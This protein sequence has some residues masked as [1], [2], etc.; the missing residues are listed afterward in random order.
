MSRLPR[1]AVVAAC[2]IL[3]CYSSV[4][5]AGMLIHLPMTEGT[6]TTTA[7]TGTIGG[8]ATIETGLTWLVNGGPAGINNAISFGTVDDDTTH[9]DGIMLGPTLINDQLDSLPDYTVTM[10]IRLNADMSGNTAMHSLFDTRDIDG[11]DSPSFWIER[12]DTRFHLRDTGDRTG[13]TGTFAAN[14]G[15]WQFVAFSLDGDGSGDADGTGRA[16]TGTEITSAS[17]VDTFNNIYDNSHTNGDRFKVGGALDAWGVNSLPGDFADVRFYD[18][19]LDVNAIEAI[20]MEAIPEPSTFA[21]ATLGLV[22]LI[23]FGRR[24][25]R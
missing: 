18:E 8:N 14:V 21:L 13:T 17:L 5:S 2:G 7:N 23:G 19:L 10:W 11:P 24:R 25:K 22:G 16:Y 1:L 12:N 15:T 3:F 20:R 4:A 9:G 6:G